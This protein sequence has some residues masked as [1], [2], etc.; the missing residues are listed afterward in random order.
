VAAVE[1]V[2]AEVEAVAAAEEEALEE[3]A[4]EEVALEEVAEEACL[5][6]LGAGKPGPAMPSPIHKP[7]PCAAREGNLP[8]LLAP[9]KRPRHS[10][11]RGDPSNPMR[12]FPGNA[13]LL[14]R[15][16]NTYRSQG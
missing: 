9:A 15:R 14:E 11:R 4:L 2:P 1:E 13:D 12:R 7:T 8:R 16:P 3:V 5:S 10:T 6:I